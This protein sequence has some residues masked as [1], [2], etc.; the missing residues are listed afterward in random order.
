MPEVQSCDVQNAIS[1]ASGVAEQKLTE[2]VGQLERGTS[3]NAQALL[4]SFN[5]QWPIGDSANGQTLILRS[6]H[7]VTGRMGKAAWGLS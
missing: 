2:I 4:V 6:A 5:K 3:A 7:P 1:V